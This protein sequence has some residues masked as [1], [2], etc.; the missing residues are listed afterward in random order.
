LEKLSFF[1]ILLT[2]LSFGL[3][4]LFLNA[5]KVYQGWA[6]LGGGPFLIFL[7]R[8]TWDYSKRLLLL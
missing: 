1:L 8:K 5:Q 7:W 3:P 4:L 2:W 6:D